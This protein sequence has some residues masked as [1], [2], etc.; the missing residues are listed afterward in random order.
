MPA[1]NGC[2]YLYLPGAHGRGVVARV[3][4]EYMGAAARLLAQF[5]QAGDTGTARWLTRRAAE[6]LVSTHRKQHSHDAKRIRDFHE[7]TIAYP[8]CQAAGRGIQ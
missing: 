4:P 3:Y 6:I 5:Q 2:R 7:L 1:A 8:L